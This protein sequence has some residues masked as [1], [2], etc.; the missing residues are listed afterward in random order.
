[1]EIPQHREVLWYLLP[2]P[3]QG[4]GDHHTNKFF[5]LL[6]PT[7]FREDSPSISRCVHIP[8]LISG[9]QQILRPKF[10]NSH[11]FTSN[12][13][14]VRGRRRVA[15]YLLPTL[16]FRLLL[17]PFA[18][19]LPNFRTRTVVPPVSTMLSLFLLYPLY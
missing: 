19:F 12:F 5:L 2:S 18:F 16:L 7:S 6:S 13:G 10:T 11:H 3:V 4:E 9:S 8:L 15:V 1:M 14:Q 17:P